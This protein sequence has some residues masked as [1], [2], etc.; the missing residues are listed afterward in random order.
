MADIIYLSEID[1]QFLK[2]LGHLYT[3]EHERL[4]SVDYTRRTIKLSMMS[5]TAT[6]VLVMSLVLAGALVKFDEV[7]RSCLSKIASFGGEGGVPRVVGGCFGG[8][9]TWA[10]S[11]CVCLAASAAPSPI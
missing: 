8:F 3:S 1:A 9:L 4:Q 6:Y 5:K 10:S 2:G 11:F 7:L